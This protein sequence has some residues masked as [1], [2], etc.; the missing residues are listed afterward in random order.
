[1]VSG[2]LHEYPVT[3]VETEFCPHYL[4]VHKHKSTTTT[5]HFLGR[6][7]L[8]HYDCQPAELQKI[9]YDV[10]RQPRFLRWHQQRG[11]Q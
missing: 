8:V 5:A 4:R 7:E 9:Q 3:P 6:T 2:M 11:Q 10:S 1:M